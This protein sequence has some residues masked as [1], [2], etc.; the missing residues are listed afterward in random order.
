MALTPE[1]YSNIYVVS[2]YFGGTLAESSIEEKRSTA[3]KMMF[4]IKDFF[5]KCDQI[6][7]S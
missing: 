6:A 4:S 5:S 7:V 3:Q 1:D 2:S